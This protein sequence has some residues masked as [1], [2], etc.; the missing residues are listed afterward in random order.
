MIYVSFDFVSLYG[1]T[2][3]DEIIKDEDKAETLKTENMPVLAYRFGI[4]AE[5][6]GNIKA[7]QEEIKLLAE[8]HGMLDLT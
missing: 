7:F 5:A 1:R 3:T 6:Y 2:Q 4:P 8:K